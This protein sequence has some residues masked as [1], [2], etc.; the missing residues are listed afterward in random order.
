MP[1]V[2]VFR[3]CLTDWVATEGH[4]SLL[5]LTDIGMLGDFVVSGDRSSLVWSS[6]RGRRLGALC[7]SGGCLGLLLLGGLGLRLGGRV[8]D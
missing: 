6:S 5:Q 2:G 3:C 1:L 8:L 4:D 7:S